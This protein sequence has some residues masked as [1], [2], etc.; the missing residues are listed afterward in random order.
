MAH[1]EQVWWEGLTN[2]AFYPLAKTYFSSI[3]EST[4]LN[5]NQINK[6]ANRE[7]YYAS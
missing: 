1:L 7:Y 5:P 6:C 3:L 4:L 2:G